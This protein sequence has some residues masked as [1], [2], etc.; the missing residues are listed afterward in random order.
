MGSGADVAQRMLLSESCAADVAQRILCGEGPQ[1]DPREAAQF[2][3]MRCCALSD[4]FLINLLRR[5]RMS[6]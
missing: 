1:G 6:E 5:R 4:R 2:L 3:A